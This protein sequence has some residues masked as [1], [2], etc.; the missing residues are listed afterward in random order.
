MTQATRECVCLQWVN[1]FVV[2]L[3]LKI[4]QVIDYEYLLY[5]IGMAFPCADI[6]AILA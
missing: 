5:G 1:V 4:I 2:I 3:R 6:S